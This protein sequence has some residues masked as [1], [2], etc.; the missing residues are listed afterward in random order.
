MDETPFGNS[1]NFWTDRGPF[2]QLMVE[3]VVMGTI[4]F[5]I[6]AFYS[7]KGCTTRR[8]LPSREGIAHE[9]ISADAKN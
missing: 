3:V 7:A 9:T 5:G 1:Q 4:G 6:I 2:S 8:P